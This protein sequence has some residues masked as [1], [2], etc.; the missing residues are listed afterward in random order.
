MISSSTETSSATRAGDISILETKGSVSG[1][2]LM[3][4]MVSVESDGLSIAV[5]GMIGYIAQIINAC[6][7]FR[8]SIQEQNQ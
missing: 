8:V 3:G 6:F 4:K 7:S 2:F 5:L 1:V